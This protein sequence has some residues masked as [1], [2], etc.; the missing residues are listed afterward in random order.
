MKKYKDKDWL[1]QKYLIEKLNIYQTG[2]L[3]NC[4]YMTI[5]RWLKKLNIQTRSVSEAKHLQ[6]A[7]HCQL[8]NKTRQWIDG[9]LLGD[10][11]LSSHSKYSA[12]F[13]YTS[14]YPQYIQYISNTLSSFGIKQTGK[15]QKKY[16]K[17]WNCY[18][19]CYVS[20]RYVELLPIYKR[21]YPKDKK[22][23][24]KDLKLTPLVLRQEMIGDGCLLH[25]KYGRPRIQ[26]ATCGFPISDVKWLVEQLNKLDFKTTRLPASNRIGI[27]TKSTR[28]FLD[29]IGECPIECYK[30]KW[31]YKNKR[32]EL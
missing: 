4:S 7:N 1:K 8:S 6:R 15:I 12:Y 20:S 28:Q 30:Y 14:K 27:S 16:N 17:R 11:C 18:T 3:C 13:R 2:K 31:N 32:R 29:Y 19:Y 23:I 21:W 26:L 24:P 10:G 22:I 25:Q 9:E 5:W